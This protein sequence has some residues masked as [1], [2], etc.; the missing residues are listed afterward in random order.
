[1]TKQDTYPLP[2][3]EDLLD[4][5]DQTKYFS[6]IDLA[7]GD[8]QIRMH[9]GSQEKT[10]FITPYGLYEF[11]VMP[12]G[13]MNAPAVFQRLMQQVISQLNPEEGP[14]FVSV[15]IDIYTI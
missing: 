15:Y 13:L 9:P 3:I 11:R 7:S 6:S 4:Q 1:M 14:E 10:T 12:F 2:R 8:W 5:L